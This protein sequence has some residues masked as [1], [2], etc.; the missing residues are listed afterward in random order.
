M[1][2]ADT[3]ALSDYWRR[4][5]ADVDLRSPDL[6]QTAIRLDLAALS[7]GRIASEPTEKIFREA[8]KGRRRDR[9]RPNTKEGKEEDER[10]SSV[11]VLVAPFGLRRW[12][13]NGTPREADAQAYYPL[14]IPARLAVDGTL[15]AAQLSPWMGREFLEPVYRDIPVLGKLEDL[16]GFLTREALA[17]SD[18]AAVLDYAE[19]MLQAVTGHGVADLRLEGFEALAPMAMLW[20]EDKGMARSILVLYDH[21]LRLES[22]PPL[23]RTLAEGAQP[24]QAPEP[25]ALDDPRPALR[26]CGQMSEAFP[27]SPSQR[28]AIHGL[29]SLEEGSLL[30]VNGPPGTGKTTFLQSAVASLWVEA[31]LAQGEPPIVVACST[32]NQAVTNILDSFGAAASSAGTSP[33]SSSPFKERWLPGL[34]SYGLYL[35]SQAKFGTSEHQ[36]ASPGRPAWRGLPEVME[37]PQ[38]LGQAEAAYLD[39][40]RQAL[41]EAKDGTVADA[42]R[43]LYG[44]MTEARSLMEA[45]IADVRAVESL[46]REHGVSCYGAACRFI[47]AEE[48]KLQAVLRDQEEL[49][50]EILAALEGIPFWED[51]LSFLPPIR[52]RRDRRLALPFLRRHLEP[53]L[54]DGADFARIVPGLI[55]KS[56]EETRA[57]LA[58][59][60]EWRETEERFAGSLKKLGAGPLD[61][62]GRVLDPLDGLRYR[63]FLLAGRYWEGRWLLEMSKLTGSGQNLHAQS[64][65]ACEARFRRFCMLTPCMVATF[66]QVPKAFTYWDREA[67][68]AMPLFSTLD[69]LIVDEAGQASPEIG[70]AAFALAKRALVVGDIHQIQPVWSILPIV[71][72]ANLRAC[73]ITPPED[74]K[75]EE[76]NAFRAC[77]GSVMLL[78]R[79]ATAWTREGERGL[80]LT[81][82]RRCVPEVIRFCNELVYEGRLQALRPAKTDRVLPALGWAHVASAA[83]TDG[84]SRIN[85]GEAQVVADWIDRHRRQ[86]QEHYG[87]PIGEIVAVITPFV[88]QRGV[89]EKSFRDFKLAGVQAGT[90][91]AFQGAERPVILFSPVYSLAEAPK[92]FFFDVEASLLNVA[93]SRAKDSF[94][95]FGDLRLFEAEKVHLPSGKL[96][97]LL[98]ESPENEITDIESAQHLKDKPGV[99]RLATLE[100]HRTALRRALEEGKERIL[101]VSPYLSINAVEAD[102]VPAAIAAARKRGARICVVFS[103]DLQP[104]DPRNRQKA[105]EALKLAGADVKASKRMHNK[106]LAMDERWITEGSFN[107]LSASRDQQSRF[108]RHETSLLCEGPDSQKFIQAAWSEAQEIR[109]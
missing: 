55:G 97:S 30:A 25:Y 62:L 85:P 45:C 79:G 21:I 56:M 84:G 15:S 41:P 3:F 92:T 87:R 74:E 105:I 61:D 102:G 19:R 93:V 86:L 57:R 13:H 4:C 27:L 90:V 1:A 101:I 31:A 6:N 78:A 65:A 83:T 42:V 82:H 76:A 37:T 22:P 9:G 24:R 100:E 7:S 16:E 51:L 108:Q 18:W 43:G 12:F 14:W 98:F 47:Q 33:F 89:L 23:L 70:A 52:K 10:L 64:R 50:R 94:L 39:K 20:N 59:L 106:T 44:R 8:A 63:L 75:G 67:Q 96:A 81:E 68:R 60:R 107:W 71:D 28:Q 103:R 88:A 38:Y 11:A 2:V 104:H 109:G 53:P 5:L 77:R 34:R 32:N 66:Y 95:V 40:A 99:R 91:H 46:R 17:G 69:L 80:L 49:H 48:A 29:L 36:V 54:H 35:P 73:G 26:H 58:K 72:F